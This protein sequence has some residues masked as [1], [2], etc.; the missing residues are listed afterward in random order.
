LRDI[1][2]RIHAVTGT[3]PKV[4]WTAGRKVDVPANVLDIGKV[5]ERFD[6][7]PMVPLD[8]G[9]RRTWDWIR[10]LSPPGPGGG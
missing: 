8:E 4:E 5:R 7:T 1:V 2:D 9:I 6:W 10:S 3:D